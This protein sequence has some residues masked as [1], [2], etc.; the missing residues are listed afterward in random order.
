MLWL[1]RL[2][3]WNLN[4]YWQ[5]QVNNIDN[6]M[7]IT[8]NKGQKTGKINS[9]FDHCYPKTI[10][11]QIFLPFQIIITISKWWWRLFPSQTKKW[12]KNRWHRQ[13]SSMLFL[14]WL[15]QI[16]IMKKPINQTIN[17]TRSIVWNVKHSRLQ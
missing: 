7:I 5:Q 15:F 13:S 14:L 10:D 16:N 4:D 1:Y 6:N 3:R 8:E 9:Q 12:K 2:N 11:V 17:Y